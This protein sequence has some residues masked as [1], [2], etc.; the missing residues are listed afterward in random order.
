MYYMCLLGKLM[1]VFIYVAC[2]VARLYTPLSPFPSFPSPLLFAFLPH[3]ALLSSPLH[4]PFHSIIQC[5]GVLLPNQKV[6]CMHI[7]TVYENITDS[8]RECLVSALE[9]TQMNWQTLVFRREG[10]EHT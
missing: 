5:G 4:S 10:F 7:R 3:L 2:I 8:I 6:R 9:C 1:A